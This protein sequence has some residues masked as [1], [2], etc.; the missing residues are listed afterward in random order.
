M[1]Y[2][3]AELI[4]LAHSKNVKIQSL[5]PKHVF[6]HQDIYLEGRTPKTDPPTRFI[7]L[8]RAKKVINRKYNALKDLETFNRRA[9]MASRTER[10]YFL[11][12]YLD[13]PKKVNERV[14]KFIQ[15]I[16]KNTKD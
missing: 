10:L 8:E 1:I 2:H 12:V 13:E 14:R 7:D 6:V 15:L 4:R 16:K 3:S 9:K 11:L 5:Y